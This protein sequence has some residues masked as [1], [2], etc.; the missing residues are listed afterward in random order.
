MRRKPRR[1]ARP[2]PEPTG[3]SGQRFGITVT[4]YTVGDWCPT[5]DGSG[6]AE[7]VA[8]QLMTEVPEMSFFF[9]LRS[10]AAVD[11]M[12]A[13]LIRHRDSVWPPDGD[14]RCTP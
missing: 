11:E 12:I 10:P 4:E 3:P 8:I 13:A 1:R 14:D 6:P 9:R 2:L 5:P 7:A